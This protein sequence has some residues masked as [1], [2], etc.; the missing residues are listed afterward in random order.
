MLGVG[1]G[2]LISDANFKAMRRVDFAL[3]LMIAL[4]WVLIG[5][6][7]LRQSG[8]WWDEP[9]AF[10]TTNNFIAA[11]IAIIPVIDVLARLPTLIA[12]VGWVWWLGLILWRI[13]RL[14]WQSTVG[15]LRRLTH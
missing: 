12:L 1:D 15:G 11:Y 8:R 6:F 7:P 2:W 4:Q 9:G 10:I 3:C 13:G 14:A 5:G